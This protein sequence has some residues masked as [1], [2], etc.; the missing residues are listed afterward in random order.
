M[1]EEKAVAPISGFSDGKFKTE[2]E[3]PLSVC[4]G[5]GGKPTKAHWR[6]SRQDLKLLSNDWLGARIEACFPIFDPTAACLGNVL[7][8]TARARTV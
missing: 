8:D 3:L 1:D 2:C 7:F 6:R 5:P 4:R